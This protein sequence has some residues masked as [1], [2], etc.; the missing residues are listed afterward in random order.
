MSLT[1]IASP[2]AAAGPATAANPPDA[3]EAD[4]A[5]AAGQDRAAIQIA[6]RPAPGRRAPHWTCTVGLAY[7]H[8]GAL[9]QAETFL[10]RCAGSEA[11]PPA[12]RTALSQVRDALERKGCAP[13]SFVVEPA[14]AQ[15][16]VAPLSSREPLPATIDLWL[17]R[18]PHAYRA[19]A[20]GFRELTGVVVVK[21]SGR[22]LVPITLSP[23]RT[24]ATRATTVDLGD[25]G[26]PLDAPITATDPRPRKEKS[27]I[28]DR[29]LGKVPPAGPPIPDRPVGA[30]RPDNRRRAAGGRSR[31]PPGWA[32]PWL[33][34]W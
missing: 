29:F 28:P 25:E 7:Q 23:I 8:L 11:A 20:A 6:E 32:W 15:L 33:F 27:L 24:R 10:T 22:Q 9:T 12:I 1:V 21:D 26:Q 18:G 16:Y 2:V 19:S 31:R 5:L 13:V 4:R 17:C 14:S 30:D 3:D 34:R